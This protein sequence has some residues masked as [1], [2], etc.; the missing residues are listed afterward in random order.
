MGGGGGANLFLTLSSPIASLRVAF[1][2][3]ILLYD[4]HDAFAGGDGMTP[5]LL[6]TFLPNPRILVPTLLDS[7]NVLGLYIRFLR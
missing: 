7:R 4:Y 2:V 6:P 1:K 5:H 3:L